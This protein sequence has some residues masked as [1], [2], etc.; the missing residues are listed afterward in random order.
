MKKRSA[1][2]T[3][4]PT[5]AHGEYYQKN[6]RYHFKDGSNTLVVYGGCKDKPIDVKLYT[7]ESKYAAG[8]T[9]D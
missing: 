7:G 8:E 3:P 2:T 5:T 6:V 9:A 1:T 4:H